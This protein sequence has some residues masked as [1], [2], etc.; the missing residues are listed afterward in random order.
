MLRHNRTLSVLIAASYILVVTTA[1]L[2]HNHSA[3]QCNSSCYV[4]PVAF[5]TSGGSDCVDCYIHHDSS[6]DSDCPP[7]SS[8]DDCSVC[9]FL[10]QRTVSVGDIPEVTSTALE[11][12]LSLPKPMRVASRI[13]SCW[14][15]RAPPAVV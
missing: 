4:V 7:C 1:P 8:S 13:A 14:H 9:R 12:Y 5:A 15:S 11:E 3:E 6:S 10:A 2:F